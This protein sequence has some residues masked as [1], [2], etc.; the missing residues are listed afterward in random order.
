[1]TTFDGV[2]YRVADPHFTGFLA[3]GDG[4]GEDE[5]MGC[6]VQSSQG[7]RA[8]GKEFDI[9]DLHLELRVEESEK[10]L[11]DFDVFHRDRED[12]STKK[13]VVHRRWLAPKK[14]DLCPNVLDT[15]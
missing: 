5:V 9:V 4:G 2:D 1:M 6:E 15:I 7:R 8:T 3:L 10:Y 11:G 13:L 12:G 14:R